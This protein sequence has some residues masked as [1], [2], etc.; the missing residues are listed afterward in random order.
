MKDDEIR[1]SFDGRARVKLLPDR[2]T[3]SNRHRIE[4]IAHAL[5]YRLLAT[6]NLVE[7]GIRLVYERD[8]APIAR[9]RAEL[10]IAR[11][12]AGGP[13]LP[14]VEP[15]PPPPPGPP[16][17]APSQHLPRQPSRPRWGGATATTAA[18]HGSCPSPATVPAPAT[19]PTASAPSAAHRP[20]LLAAFARAWP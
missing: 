9:R 19:G 20:N 6:E 18:R 13:L 8:D 14:A 3:A 11:L 12:R 7:F 5:G 2:A 16:P 4:E 15:P 1:A 17:P 10:T